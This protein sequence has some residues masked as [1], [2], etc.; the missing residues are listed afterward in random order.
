MT[1][2]QHSEHMEHQLAEN[3]AREEQQTALSSLEINIA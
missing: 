2:T 3:T 1:M